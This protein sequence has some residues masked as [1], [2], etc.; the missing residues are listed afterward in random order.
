MQKWI[1]KLHKRVTTKDLHKAIKI[2]IMQIPSSRYVTNGV[3]LIPRSI[4]VARVFESRETTLYLED[5]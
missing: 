4:L 1:N 5:R 3:L 2:K